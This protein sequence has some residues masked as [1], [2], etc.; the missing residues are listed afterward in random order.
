MI[1]RTQYL[2]R[3][4]ILA[5]ESLDQYILTPDPEVEILVGVMVGR[6]ERPPPEEGP[7]LVIDF[8]NLLPLPLLQPQILVGDRLAHFAKIGKIS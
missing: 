6:T 3:I 7:S 8:E 2:I 1:H 5:I 4:L